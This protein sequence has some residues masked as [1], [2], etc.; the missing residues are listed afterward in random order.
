M[1]KSEVQLFHSTD[2]ENIYKSPLKYHFT[3]DLDGDYNNQNCIRAVSTASGLYLEVQ[4]S[5]NSLK[6]NKILRFL[7]KT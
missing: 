1:I 5:S 4:Y 6:K 7:Y 3:G 2:L